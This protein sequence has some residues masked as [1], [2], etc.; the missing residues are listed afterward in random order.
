MLSTVS[1]DLSAEAEISNIY[2]WEGGNRRVHRTV[3]ALQGGS[4]LTHRIDG[5]EV[6][7]GTLNGHELR[8]DGH[9][10]P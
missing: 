6:Y 7:G 2:R 3:D 8:F 5:L 9:A 4:T 1:I 10:G